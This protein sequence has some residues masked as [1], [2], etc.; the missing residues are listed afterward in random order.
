MII[1]M[2]SFS[3]AYPWGSL[4]HTYIDQHLKKQSGPFNLE[5]IYGGVAPDIFNYIFNEPY[6]FYRDYLHDE[7]HNNFIKLWNVVKYGYEKPGASGFVSHNDVWGADSTAH[8]NSLTQNPAEGYVITKAT[9]LHTILMTIPE[10]DALGLPYEVSIEVCHIIVEA[11]GD[12]LIRREDPTIAK[13][14]VDSALRPSQVF[15]N[16]LINAYAQGLADFS[17]LTPYPLDYQDAAMFL[18]GSDASFRAYM[19]TYG[20][21]FMQEEP[22]VI[23]GLVLEFEALA[24]SYFTALGIILPPGTD[25]KPLIGFALLAA[26]DICQGDYLPE[27][28]A[29][30]DYVDKQMKEHKINRKF[31]SPN[32]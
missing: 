1:W 6:V 9:W 18:A 2:F 28:L 31:H 15:Q 11:S 32:P 14:L 13:K 30:I 22:A 29:T 17:E 19:V 26:I 24:Q 20:T 8:H 7:T 21:I 23:E 12:V 16:L 5:E 4:T 25:L 3:T 10:Y 27:I